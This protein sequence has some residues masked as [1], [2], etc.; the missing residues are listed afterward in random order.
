MI[1][2]P[3]I[4]VVTPSFNQARFLERTILSVLGQDYPALEYLIVDGGSTDG[5]V[6]IIRKYGGCLQ[7]W[8]SEPDGGQSDAIA[9]GFS[10]ST[11]EVL[12]WLNSDDILLPGALQSVGE[13][14]TQHPEAEVVN[15]A[16]YSIDEYDRPIRDFRRCT[17][18]WGVRASANRMRFY[19]QDGV[20]QPATFW[21]RGAY[22]AVGG[23]S[24]DLAFAMDRDLFVRL[25]ARQPFHVIRRYLAC[26]RLHGSSK[27]STIQGVRRAEEILIAQRY[28]V[29]EER[30]LRRRGLYAWYRAGS[31]CRKA[32]L[33]LCLLCGAEQFPAVPQMVSR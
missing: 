3:V 6:P 17:Y 7:E 21:R 26:F 33:Q 30:L 20:Y 12:C 31:L 1:R 28:G 29:A 32:L 25:A 18:T 23:L 9:K 15:G 10:R 8:C 11:G 13:F 5:S 27:S 19:G 24:G 16:A 2:P 22:S 14:F 4:T